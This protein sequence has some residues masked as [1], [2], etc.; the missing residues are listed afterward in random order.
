MALRSLSATSVVPRPFRARAST[1]SADTGVTANGADASD[2]KA[3]STLHIAYLC[4]LYPAVSH[5]FVLREVNALREL[6]IAIDTFS[7]HRA[8]SDQLLAQAD[9]VAFASTA[10]ILPPRWAALLAAHA[11]LATRAPLV[12]ISTLLTALGLASAGLR[13]RLWQ[14][15]YFAEAVMLWAEC[16]RRGIRHIHVHM[17]NVAADAALLASEVG[18]RVEPSQPWSWSFTLH[19][20]DEFFDVSRFRLAEK[21]RRAR[22][23]VCIS[24]FTRSQLMTLSDPELWHKLHVIHVG[25]PIE[26]FT[27]SRPEARNHNDSTIL[28][29]GRLVPQKGQAI[30]L[31]AASLLAQRGRQVKLILAGDGPTRPALERLAERLGLASQVHFAGAVGQEEL[32]ALYAG[33]SI[34]CLASFA[35][36]VPTVLMEAM[37]MELPVISTRITG[38]PELIDDGRNGLLVTPGR[39]DQLADALERLLCDPA[40]AGGLGEAARETVLQEFNTKRSAEQLNLLFQEQLTPRRARQRRPEPTVL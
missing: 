32:H 8:T 37:A 15:F 17:G 28:C 36:G 13:G 2:P 20:P 27:R 23:V 40:F 38:V 14:V 1:A 4:S 33:A 21:V 31:E 34:F 30:L 24:D 12:Y 22:I 9:R 18:S 7:I 3:A 10:T 29:V 5:T 39:A 11:R 6:G 19:G 35:E 16:Q 26:Q 25:I